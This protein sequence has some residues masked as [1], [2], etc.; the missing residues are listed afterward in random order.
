MSGPDAADVEAL[1]LEVTELRQKNEQLAEENNDLKQK[2]C[3]RYVSV[4]AGFF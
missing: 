2:V 3:L 4:F 1:R